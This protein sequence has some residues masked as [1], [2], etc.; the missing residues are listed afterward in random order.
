MSAAYYR[1]NKEKCLAECKAYRISNRERINKWQR[2][3][4]EKNKDKARIYS[5]RW[6][7]K[8]IEKCRLIVQNRR[9]KLRANGGVLTYGISE[10]LYKL[11]RGK[12]ACCGKPLGKNYQLDHIMPVALGGVNEDWN[13]QLLRAT[14]NYQKHAKHPITF[15]QER[16]FLL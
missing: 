8:N 2:E 12:C 4:R 9:A 16:G 11:Q 13:I 7:A 6:R 14:C 3:W 5:S 1:S 10:K 15:M